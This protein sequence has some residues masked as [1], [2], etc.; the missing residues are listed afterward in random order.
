MKVELLA[1]LM[2][3][4]MIHL[5]ILDGSVYCLIVCVLSMFGLLVLVFVSCVVVFVVW[6]VKV[7]TCC[8]IYVVVAVCR[9][10]VLFFFIS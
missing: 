4:T 6:F 3:R 2:W 8:Y 9:E 10:L 1:E 5:A 7:G